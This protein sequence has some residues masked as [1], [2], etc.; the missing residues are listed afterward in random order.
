M[1]MD[2]KNKEDILVEKNK[3]TKIL[4]CLRCKEKLLATEC[5]LCNNCEEG[6]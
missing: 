6:C 5:L 2:T 1:D 4:L 3:N